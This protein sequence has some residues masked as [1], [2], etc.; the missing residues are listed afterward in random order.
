MMSPTAV[1]VA[2]ISGTVV[3]V[4]V[5]VGVRVG[6]GVDEGVGSVVADIVKGLIRPKSK[7]PMDRPGYR[8]RMSLA[9]SLRRFP[10]LGRKA[11]KLERL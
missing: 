4:G 2:R 3:G 5:R 11:P 8:N 6:V 10:S 1:I 9:R 7:Q